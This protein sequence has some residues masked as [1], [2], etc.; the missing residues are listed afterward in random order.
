M[1]NLRVI[2]R[3]MLVKERPVVPFPPNFRLSDHV[4]EAGRNGLGA[5]VWEFIGTDTFGDEWQKRVQYEVDAGRDLE[6]LLYTPIYSIIQDASLPKNVDIQLLGPGGVF[7]S[8]IL[9]GQSVK[10]ATV[11]SSSFSVPIKHF[12]VGLEYS[13]DLVVF[14]SLWN[15]AVVERQVG[16]AYNALLNHIHLSPILTYSYTASNQTAPH[17]SLG[18]TLEERVFRTLEDAIVASKMDTT[19]P[20]RGPYAL[21]CS[22][23]D[24]FLL[25]RCLSRVAQQ[26]FGKQSSAIDMITTLIA[27]D[28]WS[29]TMGNISVSYP[30]VS[31]PKCY[32]IDLAL[33]DRYARSFEK[34][35]LM[36]A[37]GEADTARFIQEQVVWDCY[38]GV[39]INVAAMV[40]EVTLPTTA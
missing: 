17:A 25:E 40:E 33:K 29:G 1:R 26:G 15:V 10:F 23:A 9:E 5:R 8:E 19:N 24:L 14:N 16:I 37:I 30:G 27:Y 18:T 11:T 34:Q 20:R 36:Q 7:F 22:P 21:L 6:P 35:G 13:K 31:S 38:L 39:Y 28:G 12:G 32:L 2:T 3:D 4:R